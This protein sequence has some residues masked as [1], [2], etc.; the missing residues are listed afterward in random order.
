MDSRQEVA[1]W[2][3]EA[4]QVARLVCRT[5]IPVVYLRDDLVR[6]P[7]NA[8]T[9][10]SKNS[11]IVLQPLNDTSPPTK[12]AVN[13]A[14]CGAFASSFLAIRQ[15]NDS[16]SH[17][18]PQIGRNTKFENG[19]V[20]NC[21]NISATPRLKHVP[22]IS[23]TQTQ[24][25]TRQLQTWTVVYVCLPGLAEAAM[26]LVGMDLS[27]VVLLVNSGVGKRLL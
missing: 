12:L 26:I 16:S 13:V 10:D 25:R 4:V 2:S 15:T 23:P 14:L 6:Q 20:T 7:S 8:S 22:M 11:N 5:T 3:H 17:P 27:T 18:E 19:S 1:R 24:L 9:I 21:C